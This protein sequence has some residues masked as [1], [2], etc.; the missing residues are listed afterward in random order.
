MFELR[1]S[2]VR[3][4]SVFSGSLVCVLQCFRVQHVFVLLKCITGTVKF[5]SC[6]CGCYYCCCCGFCLNS[7][8]GK[9]NGG[10]QLLGLVVLTVFTV[11]VGCSWFWFVGFEFRVVRL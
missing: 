5:T 1:R 9:Y 7:L 2:M 6:C 11:S 4:L 10:L 3:C 8:F